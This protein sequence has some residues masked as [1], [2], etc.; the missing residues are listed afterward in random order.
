[1][2]SIRHSTGP[3]EAYYY[4]DSVEGWWNS[5]RDEPGGNR[6]YKTAYKGG[7]F[8]VPPVYHYADRPDQIVRNRINLGLT[9]ERGHQEVG[10]AGQAELNYKV[11]TL[12]IAGDNLQLFKYVVTTTAWHAGKSATFMPKPLFGDNGSGMHTHQSLWLGG[13]PLFYDETGYGG[14]SDTAPRDVGGPP[15]HPPPPLAFPHPTVNSH[16]PL[17]PGFAAP[18]DTGYSPRN[19][20]AGRR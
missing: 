17:V 8:P 15:P 11:S 20:P 4:I 6:G 3:N 1:F 12:L 14:A 7:Y 2:D 16:R 18:G 5:G 9:A 10:P 19:P 13:E